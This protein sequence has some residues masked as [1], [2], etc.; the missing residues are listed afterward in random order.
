MAFGTENLLDVVDTFQ[1]LERCF[2]LGYGRDIG[3][4]VEKFSRF[5]LGANTLSLAASFNNLDPFL[6][7]PTE[8][9]LTSSD[10]TEVGRFVTIF[11]IDQNRN[12]QEV[13]V[14]TNGHVGVSLGTDIY[15]VWRM[16]NANGIDFTGNI[17]VGSEAAPAVGVPAAANTYCNIP[18]I[19]GDIQPVNQS[20]TGIYSIP[21][22]Y[23]GI[24]TDAHVGANKGTDLSAASLVRTFGSVFRYSETLSTFESSTYIPKFSR[25]PEKSDIKPLAFSQSGGIGYVDYTLMIIKNEYIDRFKERN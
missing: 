13:T 1:D 12:Q 21:S 14:Q 9:F 17:Y 8:L 24:I 10:I 22:G 20:L 4:K 2:E 11:Y 5:T 7:T 6:D 16:Y 15:C 3:F 25:V 19:S 18:L 23:T